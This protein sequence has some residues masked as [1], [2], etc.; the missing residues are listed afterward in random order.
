MEKPALR[1]EIK[2]LVVLTFWTIFSLGYFQRFPLPDLL[3]KLYSV[4]SAVLV[5]GSAYGFGAVCLRFCP[6]FEASSSEFVVFSTMGG[7]GVISLLMVLAGVCRLWTQGAMMILVGAGLGLAWKERH[8]L[9]L[10]GAPEPQ[11]A[12]PHAIVPLILIAFGATWSLLI[13]FTPITYYDSLVYHFALPQTYVHA[14]RWVGQ[15][16]LIY[17]A[18]PQMM[19]MIWTQGLL[20]VGDT[21]SNLL[22][23][24]IAALGVSAVYLYA[25][26]F[27]GEGT[28]RWSAAFL[29]VMPAYLLLSSGGY[30]DVGLTV[31]TFLS[32]FALCLW[33]EQKSIGLLIVSGFFAGCALGTKYTGGI[34]FAIGGFLILYQLRRHPWIKILNQEAVYGGMAIAIFSPWLLKNLHYFGNPVFPFFFS[35]G[36][37]PANP[38]LGDAAA[39]YFRGLTEYA[40]RT[41]WQLLQ[42]PWNIAVHGMDFGGGMDVLGDLG[43]APLFAFLP[44]IWLAKKK[45]PILYVLLAYLLCFYMPWAMSRPVLRFLLPL[46]PLLAIGAG[47][48]CEHGLLAQKRP[49]RLL[50]QAFLTLFLLSNAHLFYEVSDALRLFQVPLGFQTRDQYLR[51]IFSNNYYPAASFMNANLGTETLTY[52][53][54]DQRR[55]YYDRPVLVTPVFNTNPLTEWANQASSPQDLENR[56]TERHITHLLVNNAEME[57]LD[58]AYNLFPF[59]PKGLSNWNGLKT[60]R[61]KLIYHDTSCDL[62]TLL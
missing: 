39:G 26:R 14:G 60:K 2:A 32:F 7:F 34:P 21:L 13:A 27:L 33:M 8:K 48:G 44:A 11:T 30:V 55:Y 45:P 1:S 12:A 53:V 17:S 23:W 46:A 59:T 62:F 5:C 54:G 36:L 19:E 25:K 51:Q 50:G 42:L 38:W 52:V 35:R 29:S 56:L 37:K 58:K 49:F 20:L 4:D 9:F 22:A 15:T 16:Q 3:F 10:L 47:F 61:S 43:W 18:F 40:P 41:G 28:A 57:R 31:Y 24:I 6:A